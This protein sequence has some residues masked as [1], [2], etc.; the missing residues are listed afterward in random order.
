MTKT[1]SQQLCLYGL[2]LLGA[3]WGL[4]FLSYFF[5]G[6]T[7][8]VIKTGLLACI[9]YLVGHHFL[10]LTMPLKARIGVGEQ[11]RVNWINFVY[12][13]LVCIPLLV[14]G[15]VEHLNYLPVALITALGAGFVE[16][17]ICRGI[18]LQ[19]AFKDGL[20]SYKN[21]L[22]A[23]LLSSL[24]FGLAHLG[25]LRTQPLDV[26]LFQVYYAMA[27]GIYFSAVVI[28]TRSLWW[29]IF[30]HFMIDFAA[31]LATA[32]TDSTSKPRLVPFLIWLF[33]TVI[34]FI[35]IRPKQ[36]QRLIDKQIWP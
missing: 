12:L 32:G 8:Y 16:E 28:R 3:N 7:Y 9:F 34:A 23:V 6:T 29:T 10:H 15:L 14:F 35:L 2:L 25:N 31:I 5:T 11:L 30:I 21:V 17:Y 1:S 13:F 33:V 26:T 22:Q 27:M 20:H 18:L 36:I 4:G 19:I 24:V